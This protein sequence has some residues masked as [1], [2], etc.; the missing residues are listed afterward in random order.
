MSFVTEMSTFGKELRVVLCPC[1]STTV[2]CFGVE[3]LCCLH[4]MFS[5]FS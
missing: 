4:L 5:Y 3:F 1:I 2:L